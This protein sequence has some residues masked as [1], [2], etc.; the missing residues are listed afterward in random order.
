NVPEGVTLNGGAPI[1]ATRLITDATG[2]EDI[3]GKENPDRN[4][5]INGNL[6]FRPSDQ[7]NVRLGGAYSDSR[8]ETYSWTNSWF[9]RDVNPDI[10]VDKSARGF[11]TLRQNFS[12]TTFL[13]VQGEY[14]Q[15]WGVTHPNGFAP[16]VEEMLF[17]GDVDAEQNAVAARYRSLVGDEY[18]QRFADGAISPG[19]AYG[20]FTNPGAANG[21]FSK[22]KFER[23]RFSGSLQ[24][25][26]GVHQ[27]E[28]GGE[29][30]KRTNRAFVGGTG[31][32]LALARFF[33]DGNVE[34][35]AEN[36]VTA[37]DQLD[38]ELAN[39]L[40]GTSY[41]GY[42]YLGTEEVDSENVNDFASRENTNIAPHEPVYFAG[43]IRDKI[44]FR[45]LVIDL[46]LR[47]DVF[48]NGTQVLTDPFS[49][50]DLYRVSDF[51]GG[52]IVND[53]GDLIATLPE[54]GIPGSI[55]GD[56]AIYTNTAGDVVGYRDTDGQFYNAQGGP[57]IDPSEITLQLGGTPEQRDGLNDRVLEDYEAQVTVMPRIG[58]SFPVTDRALFF[59]SY[60][61]VSQRPSENAL[62]TLQDYAG[63]NSGQSRIN[64]A[65]L[66]PEITTSYEIG[67]RQRLGQRA[68][69]TVTGFYRTQENKITLRNVENGFPSEYTTFQSD[70]FTTTKG[71]E[72]E[73]ELRRTNNVQFRANYTLSFAEGTGSDS[74]TA[75]IIAWRGVLFPNTLDPLA[76][77]QRH[78]INTTLDYRLEEGEG[79]M[80]GGVHPLGGFG[81]NLLGQFGSGTPYTQLTADG[82]TPIGVST[83]GGAE[84]EINSVYTGW[85][86][87]LDL[88][89]DRDFDLGPATLKAYLWVQN[90]L[91]TDNV[92]GVYRTT[93]LPGDDG[94]LA[95]P[96]GQQI[97][98]DAGAPGD[99]ERE[100]YEFIYS[101]YVDA[102]VQLSGFKT[103]NAGQIY[104][105]PRRVR[106]GLLFSF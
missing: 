62:A 96:D 82:F 34:R 43:Y 56:F 17:Y 51:G 71:A 66:E 106:L 21:G 13:Q 5:D 100:S 19:S 75:T 41:Y 48:D 101:S 20:A 22:Y 12:N 91:N 40:N 67:F 87:R 84:G 78:T 7:L 57:I 52:N 14:T 86:T 81:F 53:N 27:L 54:G 60:N 46:G 23:L 11:L 47:V 102:P 49:L 55:G 70:D 38:F 3:N 68:A 73:F 1:E 80:I 26:I 28:I 94:F 30:E 105:L 33:D 92:F 74:N 98:N 79:P 61:V 16:E 63:A 10:D 58:V 32:S 93:G 77:D 31:F 69:F 88:R 104:G 85:T 4:W 25:Q 29:W 65:N 72:F 76:F 99:P 50:I 83:N 2:F 6:N 97:L 9:N 59:A 36:A 95:S 24:S 18:V 42:N 8:G 45:D 103:N 44:E 89:V 37:Y 64:N 90:L 39:F 15:R 35:G